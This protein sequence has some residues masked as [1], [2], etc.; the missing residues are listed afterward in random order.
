MFHEKQNV[1]V[2]NEANIMV[3]GMAHLEVHYG[4]LIHRIKGSSPLMQ[5][6]IQELTSKMSQ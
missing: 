2:F 4:S 6:Y 5:L 3:A 1:K